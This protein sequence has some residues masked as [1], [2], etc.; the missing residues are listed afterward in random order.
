WIRRWRSSRSAAGSAPATVRPTCAG[1]W[2][3]ETAPVGA[4]TGGG[5]E[6][7]RAGG[8]GAR[9]GGETVEVALAGLRGPP[10][11]LKQTHAQQLLI[12]EAARKAVAGIALPRDRTMV[13]VGMGCDPEVARYG[14]RWRAPYRPE[15]GDPESFAPTLRSAGVVGTMPN[16]IANRLNAH[17]DLAGPSFSVSAE[18][19]SG[20][21]AL[22][23]AA[24]APRA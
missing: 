15:P 19:A 6:R 14:A 10:L 22:D 3:A 13:L 12:L 9:A 2:S 1:R 18:E 17:L 16:I 20:T 11:D 5:G 7:Q 8:R 24:R 4:R 21:V 23:L